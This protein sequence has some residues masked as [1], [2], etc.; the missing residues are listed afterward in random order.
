MSYYHDIRSIKNDLEYAQTITDLVMVKK[1]IDALI[2]K[3]ELE[4][5]YEDL[6]DK[7]LLEQDK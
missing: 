5:S 4:D 6:L 1:Q 3:W 2:N 7:I